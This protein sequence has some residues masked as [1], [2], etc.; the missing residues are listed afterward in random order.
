MSSKGDAIPKKRF[1]YSLENLKLA[2][3]LVKSNQAGVREAA[4]RYGI[5]K[6][7]LQDKVKD[8]TPVSIRKYVL[9]KSTKCTLNHIRSGPFCILGNEVENKLVVWIL[10]MHAWGTTPTRAIIAKKVSILCVT[11]NITNPFT[12]KK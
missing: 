12:G 5:P 6:S 11:L 4:A 3:D 10:G 1:K 2:Y 7:T 9:L 8:I